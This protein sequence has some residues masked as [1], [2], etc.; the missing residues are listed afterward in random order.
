M[1]QLPM[2]VDEFEP[3][4]D[5]LPLLQQS[6]PATVGQLNRFGFADYF[7]QAYDMHTIQV[8]RKQNGEVLSDLDAVEEQLVRE[9]N[10]AAENII[11]VEG[12]IVPTASGCG[13]L[14]QVKGKSIR[15]IS[16]EYRVSYSMFMSWLWQ[17]DKCG[18]THF[19]T[20]DLSGTAM[21]LSTM[22]KNSQKAEHSTMRRYIK[23][24]IHIEE[25][26]PQ[27]LSLM[28]VVGA[29]LGEVRARALVKKFGNL[30]RVV[31]AT[32]EEICQVDGMGKVLARKLLRSVGR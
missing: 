5:I 28:G 30:H 7:W 13:T 8:E 14:K 32:E 27:V 24:R 4:E 12:Y 3:L 15:Y 18:I 11:I 25:R 9:Y 19:F 17:L 26:N 21:L 31:N 10:S 23:P 20:A 22:Y 2:V 16:R 6:I 1:N 29:E